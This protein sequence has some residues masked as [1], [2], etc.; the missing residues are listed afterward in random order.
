MSEEKVP[1]TRFRRIETSP[2]QLDPGRAELMF[3]SLVLPELTDQRAVTDFVS[4]V[5]G[6]SDGDCEVLVILVRA[7]IQ[8]NEEIEIY[9]ATKQISRCW[10][11]A[12]DN[13][14]TIEE[15]IAALKRLCAKQRVHDAFDPSTDYVAYLDWFYSSDAERQTAEYRAMFG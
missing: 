12:R 1:W 10:K 4:W 14:V 13:S 6:A 11:L 2:V 7:F 15:A 8:Y 3:Q 9:R 5:Y